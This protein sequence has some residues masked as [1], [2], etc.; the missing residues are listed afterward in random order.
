MP[1][2][3]LSLPHL[4]QETIRSCQLCL[5]CTCESK[6]MASKDCRVR[7]EVESFVKVPLDSALGASSAS[8]PPPLQ[9]LNYR[10]AIPFAPGIYPRKAQLSN[11]PHHSPYN[12]LHR[13][14]TKLRSW[15]AHCNVG[16]PL[17]RKQSPCGSTSQS[18]I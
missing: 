14:W 18:V 9:P 5:T 10:C 15:K 4:P 2:Q 6:N 13:D 8:N 12:K 16:R 11:P 17:T 7:K 3:H 1:V